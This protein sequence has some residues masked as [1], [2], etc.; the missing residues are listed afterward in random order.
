MLTKTFILS[1]R[2]LDHIVIVNMLDIIDQVH[3]IQT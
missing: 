2:L 1:L 3:E